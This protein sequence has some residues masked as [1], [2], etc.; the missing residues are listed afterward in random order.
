VLEFECPHCRQEV[1]IDGNDLPELVCDS[2]DWECPNCELK[3][4]IGWYATIEEREDE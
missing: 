4:K 2:I 1:E 3:T